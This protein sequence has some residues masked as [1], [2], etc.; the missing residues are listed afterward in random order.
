LQ[1]LKTRSQFQAALAGGTVART[2]HFALHCVSLPVALNSQEAIEADQTSPVAVSLF[3]VY[4]VW[5]GA[6][7]PKRWA[8][9]AVTR[10]AIKRQI[11]TVS[12]DYETLLPMA[13]HVVRLR[14]GFDKAHFIS[15]TSDA[16]K[17]AVNNE[18]RQLFTRAAASAG[19]R[20]EVKK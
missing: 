14:S 2:N 18:L 20:A 17:A 1:R 4:G 15:A 6:M 9:R 16:L 10:N 3:S 13:A 5:M 12:Q 11:Y 7:V 8:K 19:L